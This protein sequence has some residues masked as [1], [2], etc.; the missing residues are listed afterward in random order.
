MTRYYDGE[1]IPTLEFA[2][3]EYMTNDHLK[4]LGA[5]TNERL[6]TRKAELVALILRQMDGE[7]LRAAWDSLDDL[8]RAAVAEVVHADSTQFYAER[9]RAKYG[10]NPEWGV[11]DPY[12]RHAVPSP[13]R[14]FFY[15]ASVMPDDLKAR[16]KAFVP[17]P[18][19]TK[20]ETVAELPAGYEVAYSEW[21]ARTNK[22]EEGVETT[23]FAVHETERTAQRE[24]FSVLRL[25]DAGKIAVGDKTQRPSSAAINA[26]TDILE[27]GDFYP[28][29]PVRNKWEDENAG[30]IRAFAWPMLIQGGGLA[31]RAG[32]KLQL[33]KAGRQAL[34]EPAAE[35]IR[36]L[37]A[38]WMN[39]GVID[40][41]SRIDCVKGQTGKGKR[42]L[43]DPRW[44]RDAIAAGL[45]ECPAGV[46]I[47][48][49]EFVR[50]L[51]A[52]GDDLLVTRD[53]WALYVADSQYGALGYEG[54]ENI[55]EERYLFCFLLEYAAT[56]GL[57]DVALIPPAGAR[58]DYYDLWGADGMA[59]FSRYD[60]LMYFRVTPLGAYC[61]GAAAAYQPAPL[62]AKPVLRVL[63]NLEIAAIGAAF[64]Q[65]DRLALDAYAV[66]VSDLVW[67]LDA[68]KLLTAFEAGRTAAEIGEFLTA[69]SGGAIPDTVA[70][71]LADISARSAQVLDRGAA[72]LI[73][74]AEPALAALI[75]N[76]SRTRKHCLRAGERCLV[77]PE[78]SV[79]AFKRNL[80]DVG[81]LVAMGEARPAKK[82]GAT[83]PSDPAAPS[84]PTPPA[85]EV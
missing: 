66:K 17:P 45:G 79:A 27:G 12:D 58:G 10:E 28:R 47:L 41:L 13:L 42:G 7:N 22:Q 37:W 53:S 5:L 9:F 74:C 80:R 8:Q 46:W 4:R 52:S 26:I 83:P 33:T 23:P 11:I 38:K 16:L 82:T 31:Q 70:R 59:Y 72:R 69:R 71:L 1:P 68:G 30:P 39:T 21:N 57:I 76:D 24:L 14:F 85:A 61:L 20:I 15:G 50:F 64:E 43:T 51:R 34:A 2:L 81:Y 36:T 65:A 63:P 19:A 6:P 60:G 62:E 73:E 18:I 54:G 84:D 56:L 78:S 55:I 29:L 77:V 32:A 75:A 67:R 40:E 44:R 35:T 48:T 25:V 3:N 49:D